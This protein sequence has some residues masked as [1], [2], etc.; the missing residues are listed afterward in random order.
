MVAELRKSKKYGYGRV[1]SLGQQLNGN[2]LE[3]QE[4]TLR[5]A[6]AEEV[7]LECFTGTTIDRPK[8]T[9]LLKKL[10]AGDTLYVT[11]L[12]RFARASDAG[13]LIEELVN[14]GVTV[15]I[16][17]F[18]IANNSPTGKLMLNI[19][20]SFA[21][22][23]RDM[24]WERTQEGKMAAREKNPDYKEGRKPLEIPDEFWKYRQDVIEGYIT[25]IAACA[26]LGISRSTWYKWCKA[27]VTV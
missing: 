3:E 25:V 26:E 27:G 19:I 18:G 4:K 2:S 14:R 21:Q 6:G 5:E 17:N 9:P 12:D 8:F 24:I 16:L 10:K 11:K 7:I 1:S 15:N 20:F 23:E 13:K 22:Y